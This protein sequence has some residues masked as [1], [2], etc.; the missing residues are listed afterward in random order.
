M[1]NKSSAK[2]ADDVPTTKGFQ[3]RPRIRTRADSY[4]SRSSKVTDAAENL[5]MGIQAQIQGTGRTPNRNNTRQV[6]AY[7]RL[8]P[9]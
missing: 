6:K 9:R 3:T 4:Q 7:E 2:V 8:V 1:A 5:D